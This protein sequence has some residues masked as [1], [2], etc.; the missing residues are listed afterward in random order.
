[1]Y[2]DNYKLV[3]S[4]PSKVQKSKI[5][6]STKSKEGM[7]VWN[8]FYILSVNILLYKLNIKSEENDKS[9]IKFQIKHIHLILESSYCQHYFVLLFKHVLFS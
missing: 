1:M 3:I 2:S 8:E 9:F 5:F 7:L 6:E 4:I